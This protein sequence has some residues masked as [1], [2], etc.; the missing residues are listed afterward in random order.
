VWALAKIEVELVGGFPWTQL[1]VSFVGGLVPAAIA[2]FV[3]WWGGQHQA[4]AQQREFT[5]R[6]SHWARQQAHEREVYLRAERRQAYAAV[7]AAAWQFLTEGV[8]VAKLGPGD[9]Q[10][11]AWE[12]SRHLHFA[13]QG[14]ILAAVLVQAEEMHP[15]AA[16]LRDAA[17]AMGNPVAEPEAWFTGTEE[18]RALVGALDAYQSAASH[19]LVGNPGG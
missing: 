16:S 3:V 5:E 7:L 15:H 11:S 9:A 18:R 6:D 8:R 12:D 14:A 13:L 4:A 19:E 1:L 2:I 10:A 17:A